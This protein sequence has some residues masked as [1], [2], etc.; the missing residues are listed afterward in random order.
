M[1]FISS[2][3][4]M[5]KAKVL[6]AGEEWHLRYGAVAAGKPAEGESWDVEKIWQEFAKR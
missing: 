4:N 5:G 1:Q 6:K 2:S 3:P